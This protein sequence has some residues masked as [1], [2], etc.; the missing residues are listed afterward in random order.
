MS[1]PMPDDWQLQDAKARFS[2]L[3]KKAQDEGPQRI[4]RHG[5]PVA[6]VVSQR[7]FENMNHKESLVEFLRSSSLGEIE[8]PERDPNDFGRE[9]EI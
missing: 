4:T 9:I 5:E 6:V 7:D 1:K 3:I 2:A 8:I